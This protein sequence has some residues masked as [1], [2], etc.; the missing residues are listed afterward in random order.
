MTR[1]ASAAGHHRHEINGASS[2][3][4]QYR[5]RAFGI[6]FDVPPGWSASETYPSSD[7]G[8]QVTLTEESTRR[9]DQRLDARRE[10]L[11]HR[12][13]RGRRGAS[14]GKSSA[15]ALGYG[16]PGML[17]PRTY[18]IPPDTIQPALI[19]GRTRS[20]PSASYS[21]TPPERF[22]RAMTTIP[23]RTVARARSR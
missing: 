13:G 14:R 17:D 10:T 18:D 20:S 23:P 2:R 16:I 7:G 21:G 3:S 1:A 9:I 8:E 19:N 6:T 4:G 12:T 15:A 22:A 5:H 11:A